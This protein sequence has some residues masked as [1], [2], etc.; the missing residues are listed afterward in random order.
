MERY[1]VYQLIDG[2]RKYRDSLGAD[3]MEKLETVHSVGDYCTMLRYYVAE[4]DKAWTMNPGDK[5][6]LDVMRKIGGIAVHCME[7][8]DAPPRTLPSQTIGQE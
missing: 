6:A 5:V 7:Q 4:L 1:K 8:H 3:R 2:E